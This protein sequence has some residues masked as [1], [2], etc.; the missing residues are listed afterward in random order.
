MGGPISNQFKN[1]LVADVVDRA[2]NRVGAVNEI[3]MSKGA[4]NKFSHIDSNSN[5]KISRNEL[6]QAMVSNQ[7][8]L[9]LENEGRPDGGLSDSI[10]RMIDAEDGTQGGRIMVSGNNISAA[11]AANNLSSGQWVIG[12]ALHHK[13]TVPTLEIHQ[14]AS[15]PK[16]TL[17]G[18]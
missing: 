11:P 1:A 5:G 10:V 17:P 6:T 4:Q 8:S 14:N 18:N 7:V 9:S 3:P 15:G 2:F 12:K 13:G 16:I